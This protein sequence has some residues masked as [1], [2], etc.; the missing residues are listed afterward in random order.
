MATE[1][2]ANVSHEGWIR[3]GISE[4]VDRINSWSRYMRAGRIAVLAGD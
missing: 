1:R 4:V 2:F 3:N